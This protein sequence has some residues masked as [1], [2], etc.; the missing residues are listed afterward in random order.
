MCT[1]IVISSRTRRSKSI[2]GG[3]IIFLNDIN[4]PYSWVNVSS[5]IIA[6]ID[7]YD[8]ARLFTTCTEASVGS[9]KWL[10]SYALK[11]NKIQEKYNWNDLVI[12]KSMFGII[13]M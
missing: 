1:P 13:Y 9:E 12:V 5:K 10:K 7:Y 4:L 8:I 6:N 11:C 2:L 3:Q